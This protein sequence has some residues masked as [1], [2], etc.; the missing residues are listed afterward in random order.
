MTKKEKSPLDNFGEF[1]GAIGETTPLFNNNSTDIEH[2]QD[3]LDAKWASKRLNSEYLSEIYKEFHMDNKALRINQCGTL[4]EFTQYPESGFKL[5]RANF[6]KAR[7][8][9]MCSWRRSLKIF[10]QLSK[11]TDILKLNGY[12]FL[13][14]TLTI[15]NCKD[16]ELKET[17]SDLMQAFSRFVRRKAFKQAFS[18]FFRALE[19]SINSKTDE[20]HPHFHVILAVRPSYFKDSKVYLSQKEIRQMWAS[21]AKLDYDPQVDIKKVKPKN[22]QDLSGA[23][24]ETAK[25]TVKDSDYL[26]G[27]KESDSHKVWTLEKALSGRRLVAMGGVFKDVHKALNLDDPEDGRLEDEQVNDE[28]ELM[29]VKFKWHGSGYVRW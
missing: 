10:G 1:S 26:T 4:I 15:R 18:G 22:G 20:Y 21:C 5:T 16:F 27:E 17:I 28:V 6:C 29:I 24:A 3:E 8:C 7:L 25:Y 14:L 2:I 23:V 9:P 11:V 13:F 19:I 12:Q